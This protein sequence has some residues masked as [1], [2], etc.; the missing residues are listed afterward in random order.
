MK[1]LFNLRDEY[2]KE[3]KKIENKIVLLEHRLAGLMRAEKK[4]PEVTQESTEVEELKKKRELYKFYINKIEL[5]LEV[6]KKYQLGIVPASIYQ[7][8]FEELKKYFP[9]IAPVEPPPSPEGLELNFGLSDLAAE[10]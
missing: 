1:E 3:V 9:D 2:Y 8:E 10:D 6:S 7:Q 5:F 4:L